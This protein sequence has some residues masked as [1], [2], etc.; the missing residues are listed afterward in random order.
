MPGPQ[1]TSSTEPRA[2]SP[3][4][5]TKRCVS[6]ASVIAVEAENVSA[7]RVNSSRTRFS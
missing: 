7:C 1:A 4:A 2:A 3:S 6:A 5:V